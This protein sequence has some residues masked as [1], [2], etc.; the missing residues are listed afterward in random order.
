[1][2]VSSQGR[3][4]RVGRRHPLVSF[5]VIFAMLG[6]M[7]LSAALGV[8]PTRV[9]AQDSMLSTATIAPESS[10]LYAAL[11]LDTEADQF[12][13]AQDLLDR[14]GLTPIL[15]MAFEEANS[16]AETSSD[17]LLAPFLGGEVAFVVTDLAISNTLMGTSSATGSDADEVADDEASPVAEDEDQV[18]GFALVVRASDPD[19]AH[20]QAQTLLQE[21]ADED[22]TSVEETEYEGVT[23]EAAPDEDSPS[24]GTAIARIGDFTVISSTAADIEPFI[25]VDAGTTAPL[26]D[27]EAFGAVQSDLND[28]FLLFAYIDGPTIGEAIESDPD[29]EAFSSLAGQDL[30]AFDAHTGLVVWADDPGFRLDS[31]SLPI[32]GAAEL[33]T[34]GNFDP[35]YDER[36][37]DDTLLFVDGQE[38]GASGTLDVIA[39]L[40][41]QSVNGEEAGTGPD[42]GT[43]PE[44]YAEE[45]FAQAEEELGFNLQTDF[46]DL[47]TGEF[48]LALTVPD[49]ATLMSGDSLFAIFLS[50]IS[51]PETMRD[52][53]TALTGFITD[54]V[55]ETTTVETRDQDGS[56]VTVISDAS[57]G[58]PLEIEF[59][60]IDEEFLL[61]LGES[62]A[63]VLEGPATSLADDPQYQDTMALLPEE[64]SSVTYLNLAELIALTQTLASFAGESDDTATIADASPACDEYDSQEE[65]QAAYD[66][67]PSLF[68]L[69]QD[70]DGEACEDAFGG[71]EASPEAEAEAEAFQDLDLSAI[72]ALG[73]VSFTRDD[74][75]RGTSLI[76]TIAE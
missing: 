25:D 56:E 58:V 44:E 14:A 6:T 17:E 69:D 76:I 32:E 68:D 26:A 31:I 45:Q 66:D 28:E 51:D 37:P 61:G 12:T 22:G 10:L 53:L 74:D 55:G 16:E 29:G 72:Q 39:L 13:R 62:I 21:N 73:M 59:G 46:V 7:I 60:V 19:A 11:T 71:A 64:H 2:Q 30:A 1:M 8:R 42:D 63:T 24:D 18:A 48:A 9:D 49:I 54:S 67:D 34:G 3:T 57:S 36:V 65:A 15:D 52:S 47:F 27:V 4:A 43:T 23:I 50:G 41:A 5:A 20:A 33:P 75:V 38:L 40:I 70:F 35:T